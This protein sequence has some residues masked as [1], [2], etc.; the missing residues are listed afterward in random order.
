[1]SWLTRQQR[2]ILIDCDMLVSQSMDELMTMPMPGK[3]YIAACHACTCNPL[4][5]AHY[6]ADW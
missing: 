2:V 3:D 4:R 5:F 1:M 6:P